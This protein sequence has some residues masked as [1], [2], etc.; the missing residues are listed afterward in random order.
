MEEMFS[1]LTFLLKMAGS[2]GKMKENDEI[3]LARITEILI[4]S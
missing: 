2:G 3:L 4:I 1:I